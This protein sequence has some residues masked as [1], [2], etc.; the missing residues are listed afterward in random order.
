DA[1]RGTAKGRSLLRDQLFE[2]IFLRAER[3]RQVAVQPAVMAAGVT[4]FV[5]RRPVPVDG[6]EISQGRRDRHIVLGRD[7][8]GP[9]SAD[10]EIDAGRLDE[11]LDPRLDQ[12]GRW[13]GRDGGD[14]VGQPVALRHVENRKALQERDGMRFLAGL[15]GAALLI[16]RRKTV[17]IDDR[18]A[19]LALADMAA[20]RKRL[21]K[22]EPALAG[23]AVLD[24]GATKDEHV[25]AAI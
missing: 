3:A 21:P 8:E 17:G 15:A 20:E 4:E 5:Q 10:A 25:D 1:E 13:W 9:V 19:V 6:L 2:D 18:G 24:D 14:V 23:K 11:R 12:A 7:V 22:C 16:F